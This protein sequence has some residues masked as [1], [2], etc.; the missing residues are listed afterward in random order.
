VCNG[1]D[2]DLDGAEDDSFTCVQNQTRPCTFDSNGGAPGCGGIA[3]T[4]TCNGSCSAWGTC[5]R[6]TEVCNYVC[7]DNANG[8]ADD[9]STVA[10]ANDLDSYGGCGSFASCGMCI[11]TTA[12]GYNA[13]RIANAA[14]LFQVGYTWLSTPVNIGFGELGVW[15]NIILEAPAGAVQPNEGYAI[16][17]SDNTTPLWEAQPCGVPYARTGLAIEWR[18]T[19][20]GAVPEAD[21]I[22]IR[23]LTGGGTGTVVGPATV[24][25]AGLMYAQRLDDATV[26]Q[27]QHNL[28]IGYTPDDPN[29]I[30]SEQHLRVTTYGGAILV[31]VDL[32]TIPALFQPN[33]AIR[34]G[35]T[36]RT[37]ATGANVFLGHET[38]IGSDLVVTRDRI[39]PGY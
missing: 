31:D 24:V 9:D 5:G 1:C 28:I 10:Y 18:F 12:A 30:G 11:C 29:T 4:Q 26:G 35:F 13:I 33:E 16:I 38:I 36:A 7:D 17:L 19:P 23:H 27:I 37:T 2:D 20:G 8:T 25:P 39:C 3:G 6:T 32:D 14:T 15:P 34:I 22:T 21:T